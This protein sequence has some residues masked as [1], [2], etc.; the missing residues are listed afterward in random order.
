VPLNI[1]DSDVFSDILQKMLFGDKNILID[2]DAAVDVKVATVLGSLV[3]KDVP[4]QGQIPVKRPSS[5]L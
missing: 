3:L 4:A 1:T 2:V 5:V